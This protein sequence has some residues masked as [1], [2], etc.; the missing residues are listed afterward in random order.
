MTRINKIIMSG[1]K[2]FATKTELKFGSNFNCILGPNGSGKCVVGDTDVYLADGSIVKIKELVDRKMQSNHFRRTEDG[3][4]AEGD[5]TEILCLD[6]RDLKIRKRKIDAFVKRTSPKELVSIRTRSGRKITSTT[7]HP[8]FVLEG[9]NIK[10]MNAE[11]LREGT[12]IAVPRKLLNQKSGIFYELID[13]ITEED[14]LYVPATVDF[15]NYLLSIKKSDWRTT[16]KRVNVPLNTIKG[17]LDNREINFAHLVAILREAGLKNE[18]IAKN[19][20]YVKSK[21]SS[22]LCRFPWKNSGSLARLFGYLIAEGRL[23]DSNQVW[24]TN[25]CV[26]VVNDYVHLVKEVFETESSINEYKPNCFDVISYSKPMQ[27]LLN[28]L[29]M[30][31]TG[32]KDKTVTNLFLKNSSEKDTAEFLNGLYC[33]DGHVS[34]SSIGITMKSR[35]LAKCIELMLT[36]LGIIFNSKY[37]VKTATNSGFS[38]VYKQITVYGVENFQKFSDAINLVH[39]DKKKRLEKL[40]GKESNPN[41]DLIESNFLVKTVTKDLAV[42]VKKEKK[43]FPRLDSYVYNQCIPSRRGLN[44]LLNKVFLPAAS[45]KGM[46]NLISLQKLNLISNSDIF[47]D[48]I[49]EVERMPS[50]EEWVYDLCVREHHNFIAENIF[51]HN[52][53][54]LDALCF[55][56]GKGSAKGLRAEKG[57]NLIYNGGKTKKPAKEGEVS[58]YFDNTKHTFPTEDREI[59]I[60]RIIRPNGQSKY[61]INDKTRTREQILDLLSVAKINPDGYNIILQGDIVEFVEM[62]P[63]QRRKV[64]EEISGIS[65]YEEKKSKALRELEK[66]D[67]KLNEAEIILTERRTRL[68]ELKSER[69]Q[70][71]KYRDLNEKIKQNKATL[72]DIQIKG[73]E[74]SKQNLDK[75]VN[76]HKERIEKI[77]SKISNLFKNIETK[78]QQLNQI[79]EEIE[80]KGEKQQLEIHKKVEQIRVDLATNRTRIGSCENEITRIEQRKNQLQKSML[81]LDDKMSEAQNEKEEARQRGASI[82]KDLDLIK[83]KILEFKK[84]NKMDDVSGIQI[85]MD[86]LDK[87]ADEKQAEIQKLREKQQELLREQDRLEFQIQSVDSK[88]EKVMEIE[89]EHRNELANL[90]KMKDD[91]K[92][93]TLDLNK[94]ITEDSTL[95][96]KLNATRAKLFTASEKFAQLKRQSSHMQEKISRNLAIETIL[97]SK[98]D[99][100]H[101]VV[102]NLGKVQSK[103]ALAL[104]IA[105]GP[106][107]KSIVVD[108]DAVA[109]KCINYLKEKKVGIATFLPMNKIRARGEEISKEVLNAKGV[110]GLAVDLINFNP[111][112]KKVFSFVFGSTIVVDDINV[113]RRIGIGTAR[114]VTL[115][116][117]LTEVSGSMHGGFREPERKYSFLHKEVLKDM[118]S[119]EEEEES[120]QKLVNSLEKQREIIDEEISEMR[121]RKATLEGEIIKLEKSLHLDSSDLDSSKKVKEEFK[122]KKKEVEAVLRTADGNISSVNKELAELKMKKQK[123]RQDIEQLRNPRLLAELNTFEQKRAELTD[124]LGRLDGQIKNTDV[125]IETIIAPEK[126]NI[127][128]ILKQHHKEEDDFREEIVQLKE[129]VQQQ[130]IE[131]KENEEAEKKFYAQF[132]ELFNKRNKVNEDIQKDELLIREHELKVKD[133]EQKINDIYLDK[134]RATAELEALKQEFMAFKDVELLKEKQD[135]AALKSAVSRYTGQL[136]AIGNVNMRAL[137]IYEQVEK[138]YQELTEKKAKL[139][140]EKEDVI[141]MMNE[142]EAKKKTLFIHTFE[143]VVE[144]FKAIF[145]ALSTKGEAYLELDNTENP[146]EGGVRVNVR[147]TGKKFL[148]IRSLSG[149]EKTMTALAFIFAIQEHDPASFYVLDEVDAALD[150]RNS[151]K[152]SQLLKKYSD[153]SQYVVISHNDGII[154]NA[155]LLYGVSMNEHGMSKVVSL[156]I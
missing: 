62:S 66:V 73:K 51:I 78:K 85:E 20:G 31:F 34:G 129:K 8:L 113:A 99:G 53:N 107:I 45:S 56:L 124:E 75:S 17:L 133:L 89:K 15:R 69:D 72:L 118:D 101:D 117:D 98:I 136:E 130:E 93:A 135:E 84:K 76:D 111:K 143:K 109:A 43:R 106:R 132:K 18:E 114:M 142:I 152:L 134:A 19:I 80:E 94:K 95:A 90:K 2:S 50:S 153:R 64:I 36:R 128:K 103:Y 4:V 16:A 92:K 146:F 39:P 54:V 67:A 12:R 97:N 37:V 138:E 104:E 150:K 116:G 63:E 40:L 55:V 77:N 48:E 112:F 11:D 59:K 148:D 65:I 14:G 28:K 42:N 141:S 86:K 68:N 151:E 145:S 110:H 41:Q 38:G 58:I 5:S 7:Y 44:L 140:E 71:L 82:E 137:E 125:Q 96:E 27:L 21:T 57:S 47:W 156:K 102:F 119:A 24:F 122:E 126:E 127:A 105:A 87:L 147:I 1:F 29:G 81:E 49:V 83:K 70:A 123:L 144:Q 23:T 155:D 61:K 30:S 52:S 35:R 26:E 91:F 74:E 88:I 149:G 79:S 46:Q 22:K 154:S 9:E 115:E 60:T 131:L 3:F 139:M 100:V 10:S 120:M 6:A 13:E 108:T 33:G 121:E 32:T 25:G